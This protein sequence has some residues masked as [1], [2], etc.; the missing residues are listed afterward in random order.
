METADCA[1]DAS[2]Q[3]ENQGCSTDDYTSPYGS[4]YGGVY[5][6]EWTGTSWKMWSWSRFNIPED[7]RLGVPNPDM[8]GTPSF[9]SAPGECNVDHAFRDQ[10]LVLN[11]D[12]CGVTA[13]RQDEWDKSCRQSTG[14]DTCEAWV[15]AHP[16][17]FTDVYWRIRSIDVYIRDEV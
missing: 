14:F 16:E 4:G 17:A 9:M 12:F 10:R 3:G 5:A 11:I 6:T 8:W 1:V 13:G 7:V 15:A 2:G